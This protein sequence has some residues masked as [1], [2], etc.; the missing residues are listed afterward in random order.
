VRPSPDHRESGRS[1]FEEG[2][3]MNV[4]PTQAGGH[5]DD[6]VA[7][8]ARIR[9]LEDELAEAEQELKAAD[10][11]ICE[12]EV[13]IECQRVQLEFAD[14]TIDEAAATRRKLE[15]RIADLEDALV[16]EPCP[17]LAPVRKEQV[18]LQQPGY[19]PG[20]KPNPLV[21]SMISQFRPRERK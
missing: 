13:T 20:H 12:Q 21:E 14:L 11:I 8:Q 19:P 5:N 15:R 10:D 17:V 2:F 18:P 9:Q 7:A 16:V 4:V 3:S 1:S 6:L